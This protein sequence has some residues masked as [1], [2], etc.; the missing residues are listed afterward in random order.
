MSGLSS[1][2]TPLLDTAA[3]LICLAYYNWREYISL[4]KQSCTFMPTDCWPGVEVKKS[5]C[6]IAATLLAVASDLCWI[7]GNDWK[8]LSD[9]SCSILSFSTDI[10]PESE[11]CYVFHIMQRKHNEKMMSNAASS[12]EWCITIC[13]QRTGFV[14]SEICLLYPEV[15]PRLTATC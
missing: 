13:Q 6:N 15:T 2:D 14:R 11:L 12:Q 7:P 5:I 10:P 3:L 1:A 9:L 8:R 4:N